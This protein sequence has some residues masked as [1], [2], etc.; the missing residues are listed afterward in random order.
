MF[1]NKSISRFLDFEQVVICEV[2]TNEI[3]DEL[4]SIHLTLVDYHSTKTIINIQIFKTKFK[5]GQYANY[6]YPSVIKLE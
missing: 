5:F 6:L 4:K 3:I 2:D 1:Y